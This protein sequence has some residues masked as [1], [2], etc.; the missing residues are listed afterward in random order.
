MVE[1]VIE[2]GLSLL[3]KEASSAVG[4]L[5]PLVIWIGRV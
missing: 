2:Q 1:D 5:R 3:K 4:P